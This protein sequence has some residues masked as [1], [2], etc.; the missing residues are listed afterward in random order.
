[1]KIKIA[2]I[3][4]IVVLA[5][6]FLLFFVKEVN[7]GCEFL[8]STP[9]PSECPGWTNECYPITHDDP[10][11]AL[12]GKCV[13]TEWAVFHCDNC[14]QCGGG[15]GDMVPPV[16]GVEIEPSVTGDNLV[17]NPSFENGL[18]GWTGNGT[19]L[20]DKFWD[21]YHSPR[22]VP[23]VEVDEILSQDIQVQKG[24]IYFVRVWA[25]ARY[26]NQGGDECWG[27]AR[28][29]VDGSSRIPIVEG[30]F[31]WPWTKF[32]STFV[33]KDRTMTLQLIADWAGD[34]CWFAQVAFDDILVKKIAGADSAPSQDAKLKIGVWDN[35]SIYEYRIRNQGKAWEIDGDGEAIW[36]E[37][38]G[39]GNRGFG[40]FNQSFDWT[41]SN[42]YGVDVEV[43]DAY[44]NKS[45]TCSDTIGVQGISGYVWKDAN[46]NGKKG[47]DENYYKKGDF[48]V[49]LRKSTGETASTKPSTDDGSFT[50]PAD[51]GQYRLEIKPPPGVVSSNDWGWTGTR[52]RLTIPD[53][54]ADKDVSRYGILNNLRLYTKA[55]EG[56]NWQGLNRD[57]PIRVLKE[58]MTNAWLGF[59]KAGEITGR[60]YE[61]PDGSCSGTPF[62]G[63]GW[64]VTCK[65][66]II[67]GTQEAKQVSTSEYQCQR[68][69]QSNC[70]SELPRDQTYIMNFTPPTEWILACTQGNLSV[71]L[72]DLS[73]AGPNFY[74]WQGWDAWFQTEEGDVHAQTS[75]TDPIPGTATEPY[76][77]LVGDGGYPG[78][79]SYGS[80]TPDFGDGSASAN[81]WLANSSYGGDHYGYA[82]FDSLIDSP[83][84]LSE[85]PSLSDLN[86]LDGFYK[87]EGSGNLTLP[88]STWNITSANKK[89]VILVPGNLTIRERINLRTNN[90]FLA[91]IVGGNIII[92]SDV[93]DAG[94]NP[95]LEGIFIAD[96]RIST[97]VSANVFTGKGMFIGWTG[98]SLG[99]DLGSDNN[100]TPAETFVF[101]PDLWISAPQ[102]LLKSSYT[103]QEL[104][105]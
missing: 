91:F 35:R 58:K 77:S 74:I 33:A 56:D 2:K 44:A 1:M 60:I 21:G 53:L 88:D 70:L 103:W 57:Y 105:P 96:G 87:V 20:S 62:S 95:A 49:V 66:S 30:K 98:V 14:G 37:V 46:G 81:G 102:E 79:I 78:V 73:K 59:W 89:V 12:C 94:A 55:D 17:V 76:C 23:S 104:A 38:V 11:W 86:A 18:N 10:P 52:W 50:F 41:L 99:R 85:N 34:A 16:C 69:W 90:N 54:R 9:W 29:S 27:V 93:T 8:D 31:T 63:T 97:G 42:S 32:E 51:P 26:Y 19:I 7:A 24:A 101:R 22:T 4:L 80:G 71:Y 28:F 72:N 67:G 25:K 84:P 6:I 13:G 5:P 48:T 39:A 3:F 82:Y 100:E 47:S 45:E 64:T 36:Q 75:I 40:F 68:C 92:E 61:T 15:G 83:S 65:A 43:R